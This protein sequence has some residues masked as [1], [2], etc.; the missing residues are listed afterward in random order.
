MEYEFCPDVVIALFECRIRDSDCIIAVALFGADEFCFFGGIPD[1]GI[2]WHDICA[3]D[4]SNCIACHVA[5]EIHNLPDFRSYFEQYS[6]IVAEIAGKMGMFAGS[7][8]SVSAGSF[9][10]NID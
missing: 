9:E 7:D 8:I 4:F 6:N 10:R 2:F 5:D 3:H 1:T